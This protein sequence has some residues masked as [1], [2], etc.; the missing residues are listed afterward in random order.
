MKTQEE[1]AL[2]IDEIVRRPWEAFSLDE[3]DSFWKEAK[4][5][6]RQKENTDC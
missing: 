6:E 1:Y 2:E 4:Q 3:L 5:I